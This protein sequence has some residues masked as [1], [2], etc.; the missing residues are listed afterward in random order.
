MGGLEEETLGRE[1][2]ETL[3]REVGGDSERKR[4]RL[5]SLKGGKHAHEEGMCEDQRKNT[6]QGEHGNR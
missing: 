3:G 6:Q 5:E 1:Y 2:R 4:S